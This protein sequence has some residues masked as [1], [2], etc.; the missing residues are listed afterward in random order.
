VLRWIN[1][2]R[3]LTTRGSANSE[4]THDK[5]VGNQFFVRYPD[6]TA[7]S[8]YQAVHLTN[9][10]Y[11]ENNWLITE[12]ESILSIKPRSVLEIGCGNGRFLAAIKDR[13]NTVIGVDWARSPILDELGISDKFLQLDVTRD[14]LPRADVVCSADVLEHIAPNLLT[15]TIVRLDAAG[16]EQYHVIACYDDGHSHLSIMEPHAWLSRFK[17]VSE[18]YRIVDIRPRRDDPAQLV[19]VIATFVPT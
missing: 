5:C 2:L 3:R 17:A 12:I 18:R 11:K 16:S 10:Y 15:P 6:A 8:Y 7:S 4:L 1:Q 14:Q 9:T 19:C 13:V